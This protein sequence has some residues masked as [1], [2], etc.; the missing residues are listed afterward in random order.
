MNERNIVALLHSRFGSLLMAL[1]AVAATVVSFMSGNISH[2]PGDSGTW[3]LSANEWITNPSIS[4][5]A[6]LLTNIGVA[7][8]LIYINKQYNV[9][10]S[11]S[12]LFAGMFL[13]MQM[14]HPAIFGQF[15]NGTLLCATVILSTAILFSSFNQPFPRQPIFLIFLMLCVGTMSQ[16]AF[17]FYIPLFMLGCGQMRI[18]DIK[19]FTAALIGI[20]TPLWI[21]WGFGL[22]SVNDFK[23]PHLVDMFEAVNDKETIQIVATTA[24]TVLLLFSMGILNLMRVYNLNSQMRAFNGFLSILS[25]ATAICVIADFR[26]M[27]TY[28]PLLNCCAAFQVGHFFVVNTQRRSYIAILAI[29]AIYATLYWWST[30]V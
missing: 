17:A 1:I 18:F 4:L 5:I 30:V 26:N 15:H 7:A 11:V 29:I 21:M 16:Y 19:T 27:E 13:I 12:H 9:L 28:V 20:I 14:A 3:L 22:I 10:R 2:I 6:S 24:F 25:F 8:L 23:M